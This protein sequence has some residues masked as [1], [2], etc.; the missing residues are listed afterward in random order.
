MAKQDAERKLNW[1]KIDR[2]P[3]ELWLRL[4]K[5]QV[6]T[7]RGLKARGDLVREA[8]EEFLKKRGY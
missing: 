5:Y 7:G 2:R 8:I 6:E 1:I 4:E 3:P